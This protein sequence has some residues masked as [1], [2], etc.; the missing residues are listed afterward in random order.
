MCEQTISENENSYFTV[1]SIITGWV[2][3]VQV[4]AHAAALIEAAQV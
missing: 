2:A 4:V 3:H 1:E